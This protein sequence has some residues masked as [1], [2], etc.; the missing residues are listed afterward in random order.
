MLPRRNQSR[1][2]R[3]FTSSS[4]RNRGRIGRPSRIEWSE[5]Q[6]RQASCT[7]PVGLANH[8]DVMGAA[9]CFVLG[10]GTFTGMIVRFELRDE[11]KESEE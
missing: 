7:I 2:K 11:K 1:R 3:L 10:F 4:A 9:G 5:R 8:E 6:G